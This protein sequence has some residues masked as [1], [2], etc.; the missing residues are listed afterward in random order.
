MGNIGIAKMSRNIKSF[1][2][3]CNKLVQCGHLGINGSCHEW[4]LPLVTTAVDAQILF[5][6]V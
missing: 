3:A 6:G 2:L 1:K 5:S 4:R